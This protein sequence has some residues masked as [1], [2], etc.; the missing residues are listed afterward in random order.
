MVVYGICKVMTWLQASLGTE[1][2]GA[3]G[4][5]ASTIERSLQFSPRK[6]GWSWS[7]LRMLVVGV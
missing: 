7:D 3:D 1:V 2:C 6:L 4:S 5:V